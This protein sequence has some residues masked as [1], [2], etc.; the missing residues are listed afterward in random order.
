MYQA[1][2]AKSAWVELPPCSASV[3]I[4]SN[5]TRLKKFL[6]NLYCPNPLSGDRFSPAAD[7]VAFCCLIQLHGR[8]EFVSEA[9]KTKATG[10]ASGLQRGVT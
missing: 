1:R 7:V 5:E 4:A 9:F 6:L 3:K 10:A 2:G 8:Q